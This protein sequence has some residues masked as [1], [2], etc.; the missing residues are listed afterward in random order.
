MAVVQT[1]SNLLT[2]TYGTTPAIANPTYLDTVKT[3]VKRGKAVVGATDSTNSQ[4]RMCQV[5][6]GDC[7]GTIT[8]V[9]DALGTG[10]SF[11]LGLYET[12]STNPAQSVAGNAALFVATQSLVSANTGTNVRYAVLTANSG[13]QRIWELLGLAADPGKYY[14]LCWTIV[15]PGTTGGTIYTQ[16]DYTR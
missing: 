9:S 14:D 3:N 1:N 6:S 8:I 13:T 16:Y 2:N 10:A 7:P 11:K 15:A 12:N 4:Y 5:Y